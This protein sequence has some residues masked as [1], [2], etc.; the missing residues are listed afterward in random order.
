[1][2]RNLRH[3]ALYLTIAL[4]VAGTYV[5][6]IETQGPGPGVASTTS[7]ATSS[8]ITTTISSVS[9]GPISHV[10]II[11]MENEEYSSIVG[12]S[13][14]PYQNYLA[15][16]YAS[17][18]NYYAATHPSLPN[19][20]AMIGGATF[21]VSSDC[22]PSQCVI[23]YPSLT[24]VLDEHG[25]SWKEYAESMP[26]N[27]SQVNSPDGLYVP[28]HNPFVYF[29][30]IT[31]NDGTGVTSSYCN[32]RVVSFDQFWSDLGAGK[33]PSFSFVTPNICDDAHSCPLSTGDRWL[34][35]VVP[36]IINSSSFSS[37]ALFITYDE[38][39]TNTGFGPN[40]GG[41]VLC[42]LVSPFAVPGYVSL[43]QYSHYSLLATV[44][45]LLKVG[46]LGQNDAAVTPMS[47]LFA[48]QVFP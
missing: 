37:T 33:L 23:A 14:A 4:A 22:L 46:N 27:C 26:V 18:A 25:L 31:G 47:D 28:K 43:V 19:Y 48:P 10:I 13:E 34:S 45:A 29:H 8:T 44:E 30:M 11:V 15:S 21:G 41:K 5:I 42:V 3:V 39:S 7:A 12:S 35:S 2:N 6:S 38:G 20:L 32:S 24:S 1:M 17:A 40:D 36:K 16:H 9:T